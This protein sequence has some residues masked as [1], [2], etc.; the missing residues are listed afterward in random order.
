[1]T[2]NFFKTSLV[3]IALLGSIAATLPS[4]GQA[5]SIRSGLCVREGDNFLGPPITMTYQL[6]M[7][8]EGEGSEEPLP[9]N[10]DLFPNPPAAGG[11]GSSGDGGTGGG[12]AC[13]GGGLVGAMNCVTTQIENAGSG[14]GTGGGSA[15][16]DG[17][18]A[19]DGSDENLE[20]VD[21]TP[22]AFVTP[23]PLDNAV[24]VTTELT[25]VF[26]PG[27]PPKV[28]FRPSGETQI[29]KSREMTEEET[30]HVTRSLAVQGT[31][32]VGWSQFLD[33][34]QM[35]RL[36]LGDPLQVAPPLT[37][38]GA[39]SSGET[40]GIRLPSEC[41][42]LFRN[43]SELQELLERRT[44]IKDRISMLE[45][46]LKEER[47]K[48]GFIGMFWD[49]AE[50]DRIERILENEK[51]R[52]AAVDRQ[53]AEKNDFI[54]DRKKR[55]DEDV[56]AAEIAA[57]KADPERLAA[58]EARRRQALID[59]ARESN[60]FK[61][62]IAEGEK[63]Y[64]ESLAGMDALIAKAEAD[65]NTEYADSLRADKE[66]L[67]ATR[68]SWREA[69][70][71]MYSSRL[72]DQQ[73]LIEENREDGIGPTTDVT[74]MLLAEG[75]NPI[76][77]LES[78]AREAAAES[79]ERRV[80]TDTTT[81]GG[82]ATEQHTFE[83]FLRDLGDSNAEIWENPEIFAERYGA[84]LEGV[85]EGTYD[86]VKDLAVL[87]VE[88]GDTAGEAFES[89]LSDMTGYEFNAFGR[90]NLDALV[91]AG[92][93][94]SN[95]DAL[96]IGD[97]AS[98]LAGHLDRKLERMAGQ[99]E[100]GIREALKGTGYAT[101]TVLAAEEAVLATAVKG[102][103]VMNAATDVVGAALDANRAADAVTDTT[104]AANAAAD[105]NR[106]AD[107]ATDAARVADGAS[108]V[109]RASDAAGGSTSAA[110][111]AD[112]NRT[113]DAGADA[114]RT[115]ENATPEAAPASDP[116]PLDTPDRPALDGS[117]D[118]AN[119]D[120]G[121]TPEAEA[122]RQPEAAPAAEPERGGMI[123]ALEGGGSRTPDVADD[124]P[125]LITD[126]PEAPVTSQPARTAD[127]TP[128]A[129]AAD[130]A[131]ASQPA[132]SQ[133]ATAEPATT[134]P[135]RTTE[136]A[137]ATQPATANQPARSSQPA[138]QPATQPS[139][140]P[141]TQPS[142]NR[143]ATTPAPNTPAQPART[144]G[145][146]S[147]TSNVPEAP[148]KTANTGSPPQPA[149][150]ASPNPAMAD[151]TPTLV[152]DGNA[153]NAPLDPNDTPTIILSEDEILN[154]G[155][156][157][158]NA[159]G[160][161]AS[162]AEN[163]T[164]RTDSP[165]TGADN[166]A[167]RA[168]PEAPRA[169]A[170]TPEAGHAQ[171]RDAIN[172]SSDLT[173]QQKGVFEAMTRGNRTPERAAAEAIIN[174]GMKADDVL[175]HGVTD[176]DTLRKAMADVLDEFTD[177]TPD[178]INKLIDASSA[179]TADSLR[180]AGAHETAA[181][182]A[183]DKV[184]K[185]GPDYAASSM[186]Y[187]QN[188]HPSKLT[189]TGRFTEDGLRKGLDDYLAKER[190]ITDAAERQR[191]IDDWMA[192]PT[193]RRP[194]EINGPDGQPLGPNAAN[195]AGA[196]INVK[197]ADGDYR[198]YQVGDHLGNGS[199]SAA[200]R[201]RDN[202]NAVVRIN[203]APHGNSGVTLE[204]IQKAQVLDDMGRKG[205]KEAMGESAY[206]EDM[207]HYYSDVLPDGRRIEVV[208]FA[209]GD[210]AADLLDQRARKALP[211]DKRQ[212]LDELDKIVD[213]GGTLTREQ[214]VARQKLQQDMKALRQFEPDEAEALAGAIDDLNE[215][216]YVVLDGHVHNFSL[217]RDADGGV[218][219]AFLD[220]GGIV[221]VEGGAAAARA[222]QR[223]VLETPAKTFEGMTPSMAE[224][225]YPMLRNEIASQLDGVIDYN[226]FSTSP[227]PINKD[228]INFR[229]SLGFEHPEVLEAL[230]AFR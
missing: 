4:A 54:K 95:A 44:G 188:I 81:L 200:Y 72:R 85:G 172:A 32:V 55:I 57:I 127:N 224:R 191:L 69:Y 162:F 105:A 10:G 15:T 130:N 36:R 126:G 20:L 134:P 210:V 225:F 167:A 114:A 68:D 155:R 219:V 151:D 25:P 6:P 30:A 156:A 185:F 141:A 76:E 11:S 182:I 63:Q 8:P 14:G 109:S 43:M 22:E 41:T 178:E 17:T 21:Q 58:E 46:R 100:E 23:A 80:S 84:Y 60:R 35:E 216:G 209:P 148:P 110:A 103:R 183:G 157:A 201:N 199:T 102:A 124:T 174:G 119:L 87:A 12:A 146:G 143:P 16:G 194:V 62:L 205:L 187:A 29:S 96:A 64:A 171:L 123:D 226:A 39:T 207:K 193:Q 197:T 227:V 5:L 144:A 149:R 42:S 192:P 161:A 132:T 115:A 128:P 180:S 78:G 186:A 79:M 56:A 153:P 34:N 37:A 3:K 198:S 108:D 83:D 138:S 228:T 160:N 140:Q 214:D 122:P 91:S 99:G 158:D 135:T 139:A 65:G 97:A 189:E 196:E 40:G 74:S 218:T 147:P 82:T 94:I 212:A 104:R 88:A 169:L 177:H 113:T 27:N 179:R 19:G 45:K 220:P 170:Q 71:G 47:D 181:K 118:V 184:G 112:V 86:A 70:D 106:A 159:A 18:T 125:T 38:P 9:N 52:L 154:A 152:T 13:S 26:T 204:D 92:D 175:K 168:T 150:D 73:R 217:V 33:R 75:E 111:A 165:L 89:G 93:A 107:T 173:P 223:Q 31:S 221:P 51:A 101:A 229:A 230:N 208:E 213:E 98:N 121:A 190:G 59:A 206:L 117:N 176:P 2:Q 90:E 50:A 66:R 116:A 202:P 24:T 129:N 164:I 222:A 67:E 163:P 53:V 137:P 120:R 136:S 28:I 7:K 203:H 61:W 48:G 215:A 131:P 166:A 142:T 133:P 145:N 195:L 49:S 211:D 77:V 1:M